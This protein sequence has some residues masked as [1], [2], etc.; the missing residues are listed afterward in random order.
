[1]RLGGRP[2]WDI[3]YYRRGDFQSSVT[4]RILDANDMDSSQGATNRITIIAQGNKIAVYM[5]GERMGVFTDSKLA[6]GRIA[7]MAWQESG[8]T[9]CTYSN[10]WLWVLDEAE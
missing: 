6:E 10:T 7:F 2:L 3:E 9:T 8:E 4:G 1:M 5:N